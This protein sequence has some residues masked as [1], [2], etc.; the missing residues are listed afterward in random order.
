MRFTQGDAD[1][2]AGIFN[3]G[4]LGLYDSLVT[5]NSARLG[6]GIY[7]EGTLYL[8]YTFI[9]DNAVKKSSSPLDPEYDG[10]GIYNDEGT[11]DIHNRGVITDNT[12]NVQGQDFG[13]GGG[14]Y[15]YY[16]SVNMYPGSE[17]TDNHA[18]T[19]GGGFYNL[20]G[21]ITLQAGSIV[22]GNVTAGTGG[23]VY[24]EFDCCNQSP[25][26]AAI[27]TIIINNTPDNCAGDPA[28]TINCVG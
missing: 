15:N 27:K 28:Q 22:R 6:G 1:E 9:S 17:V 16:G 21:Q 13:H 26:N 18:A 24:N 23:G 20:F 2:G 8:Y 14:I 7:N 5:H 19:H 4:N 3:Q 11:V 10:G 25:V 12:A